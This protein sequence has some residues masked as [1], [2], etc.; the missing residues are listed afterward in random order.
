[1][2]RNL[3]VIYAYAIMMGLIILVGFFN[4]GMLRYQYLI[5]V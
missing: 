5:Y 2:I 4:L 1:M 3:N